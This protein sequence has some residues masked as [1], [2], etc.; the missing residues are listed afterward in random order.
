MYLLS[1]LPFTLISDHQSL[2]GAFQKK[3]THGSLARWLFFLSEYEFGIQYK[4]GNENI[5][6]D[7]LSRHGH[8]GIPSEELPDEREG[9]LSLRNLGSGKGPVLPDLEERLVDI[10]NY[11]NGSSYKED[12]VSAKRLIRKAS[13]KHFLWNERLFRRTNN[14]ARVIFGRTD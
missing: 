10:T 9:F 14:G 7:F 4:L 3:G 12:D 6:P 1:T 5:A 2:K 11:L 13:V 8:E